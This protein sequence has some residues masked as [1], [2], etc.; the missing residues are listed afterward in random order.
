MTIA[1]AELLIRQAVSDP[2]WVQR[3]NA[4]ADRAAVNELFFALDISFNHEEFEQACFNLL[5]SC[6]VIEQAEAVKEV[7]LWWNC[8]EYILAKPDTD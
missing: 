6:Q 5:T 4:A 3:I 2:E 8:L 7:K 1:A